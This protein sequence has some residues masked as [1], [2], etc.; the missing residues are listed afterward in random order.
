[1]Q[2]QDFCLGLIYLGLVQTILLKLGFKVVIVGVSCD[3]L[4]KEWLG[5]KMTKKAVKE[6]K[7][8]AKKYRF[9]SA[10]EGGEFETLVVD[11]P[12]FKKKIKIIESENLW[13]RKTQSGMHLIKKARLVR[14]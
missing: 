8:L 13:D 6:L 14:K 12:L 9:H 11:C 7:A 10:G 1:M 3:G 4:G 2:K 5:K